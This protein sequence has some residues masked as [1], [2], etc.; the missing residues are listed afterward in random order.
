MKSINLYTG[1]GGVRKTTVAAATALK[2]ARLG[3]KT[4][5][6][7]TEPAHSLRDSFNI[8]LGPEPKKIGDN[9]FGQEIDVYYSVEKYWGK[10]TEFCSLCW[11]G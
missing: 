11:D 6:V 2:C 9:L 5:V 1:K 7:S 8:K 4:I 3:Y 10:L